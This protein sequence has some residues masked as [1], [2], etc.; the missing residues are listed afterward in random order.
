MEKSFNLVQVSDNPKTDYAIYFL[1][2]EANYWW[3]S[4]RAI[5]G[6]GPVTW[7]RFTELFLEKYFPDCMRNQ[8]EIEFLE[9]KKGD[10]SVVE[11]EAKFIELAR[12]LPDY[13]YS[14]AQKSRRFQQGLMPEIGSGVVPLQLKTYPFVVQVALV[15]ESD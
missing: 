7:V 6:E 11:Y 10:K 15:I 8:M 2:N 5:E 13:V 4:T 9:L 12:F 3:E 1:K 14:K